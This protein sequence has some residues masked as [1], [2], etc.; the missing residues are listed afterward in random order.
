MPRRLGGEDESG[1]LFRTY[2]PTLEEGTARARGD[3]LSLVPTDSSHRRKPMKKL[4]KLLALLAE[5]SEG[6]A[7]MLLMACVSRSIYPLA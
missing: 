4:T 3:S 7:E 5:S 2:E 6:E 1:R